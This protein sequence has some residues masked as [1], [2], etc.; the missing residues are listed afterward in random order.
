M[1]ETCPYCGN[2]NPDERCEE[3][4]DRYCSDCLEFSEVELY[5]REKT[6][7]PIR[8]K[9]RLCPNCREGIAF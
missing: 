8:A 7:K 2:E 9:R 1:Q 3:C 4:G 5:P 6:G